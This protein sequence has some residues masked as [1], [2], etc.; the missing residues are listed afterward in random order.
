LKAGKHVFCEKPLCLTKEELVDISTAYES[1]PAAQLLLVGFNRRF[2]PLAVRM[3]NF[4]RQTAEPLALHYRVNAGSLAPDHWLNDPLQGGGRL[5][6]EVC[7]F[8]D[9]LCFLTDSSPVEVEA[10]SL[11]NS[12]R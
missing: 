7:H 6:G 8:V 5:I 3:K 10:R 9:F 11:P 12:G 2:A 1:T 4:L